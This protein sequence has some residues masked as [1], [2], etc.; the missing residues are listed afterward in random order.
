MT[1]GV[2]LAALASAGPASIA[3]PT[4]TTAASSTCAPTYAHNGG[5]TYR[6]FAIHVRRADCRTAR[7]VLRAYFSGHAKPAGPYPRDG[8]YVNGWLCHTGPAAPQH[9]TPARCTK[10]AATITARWE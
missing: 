6:W 1:L 3:A 4:H 8:D 10:R 5:A 7:Q 9:G 2:T